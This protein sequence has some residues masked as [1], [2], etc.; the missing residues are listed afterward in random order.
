MSEE[1]AA[2]DTRTEY[3][4]FSKA[5]FI[6][7][8]YLK[9]LADEF[10]SVIY[11]PQTDPKHM[12]RLCGILTNLLQQFAFRIGLE[13]PS[14]EGREVMYYVY[15]NRRCVQKSNFLDQITVLIF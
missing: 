1:Q 13:V 15:R 14:K 8:T 3:S 7:R 5:S 9:D 4:E 2:D 12:H 6:T 10:F 11:T